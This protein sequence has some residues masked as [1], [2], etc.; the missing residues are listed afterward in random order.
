MKS[1]HPGARTVQQ[2]LDQSPA[3]TQLT[4]RLQLSKQCLQAVLPLIA[5]AMR[6]AVHAG[7]VEFGTDTTPA[8]GGETA[9]APHAYWVLLADNAAVAAKLRQ[10]QPL[11]LQSLGKTGIFLQEIRIQVVPPTT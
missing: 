10:L 5:P 9:A 4:A 2:V 7:P 3:L 1:R 8:S 6:K 11:M